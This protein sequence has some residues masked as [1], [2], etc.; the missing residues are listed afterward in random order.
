MEVIGATST[1]GRPVRPERLENL[2]FDDQNPRLSVA[3]GPRSQDDLLQ[4]VVKNH[5]VRDLL[6][7][8]AM[9]GYFD[10]EPLVVV[11]AEGEPGKFTV[12]EGNRRLAALMLLLDP[13]KARK[14]RVARV[15]H[16]MA[17]RREELQAVPVLEYDKRE[18]VLPYLGFRHITGVQEWASY[19]KARYVAQ[20]VKRGMKL[21]DIGDLIGDTRQFVHRLYRTYVVW[22]QAQHMS[23]LRQNGAMSELYFSYLYT[24][25]IQ[26]PF[27]DF[28]GLSAR[29]MPKP[30]PDGKV[31]RLRELTWYLYGEPQGGRGAVIKE[32]RGIQVLAKVI[33]SKSALEKLRGGATLED[34][35][36]SLPGERTRLK[37]NLERARRALGRAAELVARKE[38]DPVLRDLAKGCLVLAKQLY[39][40][41]GGRG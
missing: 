32:S 35:E 36:E 19:A 13:A 40:L 41:F 25:L 12:V 33:Q 26:R 16:L 17:H 31:A 23:L 4:E 8:F 29:T 5:P 37:N 22:E 7:S 2:L 30:V 20:L 11:P 1:A 6:K 28:L 27:L 15:P 9:N 18:Q 24:A 34:A 21:N 39:R 38:D 10:E 14:L 3:D